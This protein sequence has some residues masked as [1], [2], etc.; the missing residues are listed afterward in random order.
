MDD[1]IDRTPDGAIRCTATLCL[2]L[3]NATI[4]FAGASSPTRNFAQVPLAVRAFRAGGDIRHTH[5]MKRLP[6]PAAGV[7]RRTT[8]GS[9]RQ[10]KNG[11]ET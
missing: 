5:I 7:S 2:R 1:V 9:Q 10:K 11:A 6:F 3:A 4:R 8:R